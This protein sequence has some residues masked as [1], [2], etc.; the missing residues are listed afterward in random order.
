MKLTPKK[1][2]EDCF[3]VFYARLSFPEHQDQYNADY[4]DCYDDADC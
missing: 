1:V 4:Y 3:C 2:G